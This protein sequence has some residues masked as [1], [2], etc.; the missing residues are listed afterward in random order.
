MSTTPTTECGLCQNDLTN[1]NWCEPCEKE[2][3]EREYLLSVEDEMRAEFVMSWV[4]GGGDPQDAKSAY[5]M[6]L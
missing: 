2:E 3:F 5:R 1:D 4:C 6:G